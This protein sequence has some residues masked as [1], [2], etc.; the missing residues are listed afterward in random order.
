MIDILKIV[1]PALLV[2]LTSYLLLG[3]ML[4]NEEDRRNNK[5]KSKIA[6]QTIKYKLQAY[7]R[8]ALVLER[9]TPNMLII[10][11]I[12]PEMNCI[13]LQKELMSN[14]RNEFSHNLSQ[15]IYVSDDLWNSMKVVQET[16]LQLVIS[17]SAQFQPTNAATDLAEK[18]IQV[19][20]SAEQTPTNYAMTKL[21]DEVRLLI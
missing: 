1:L 21:K 20:T 7:E 9:T 19:Y 17:C 18:I 6:G 11:T 4:K 16:L 15:Q 14:I 3:K 8:L 5:L 2:L 12:T 13:D 10:N